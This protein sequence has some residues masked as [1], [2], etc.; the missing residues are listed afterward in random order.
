MISTAF[1]WFQR[2]ARFYSQAVV[3]LCLNVPFLFL[4]LSR[5]LS[6]VSWASVGGVYAGLVFLGYYTLILLVV[7]TCLFLV[8][9]AWPRLFLAASGVL[10]TLVLYYFLVDGVVYR[11]LKNHIDAFWL[12]YLRHDLRG[13]GDRPSPDRSWGWRCWPASLPW[14]GGC[15]GLP[16]GSRR[17]DVG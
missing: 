17:R 16:P 4:A 8:T 7:I 13:P 12:I 3:V 6:G 11:I 15:S 14:S 9:G 5:Y 1:E 10:I 2:R